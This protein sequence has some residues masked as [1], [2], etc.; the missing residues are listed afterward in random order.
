MRTPLIFTHYGLSDY[1]PY[2]L[3]QARK[4][5]PSK[6]CVLIGD[7]YNKNIA[8]DCG[9]KHIFIDEI[10]S[11]KRDEFNARFKWIQGPHHNPIRGGKDWLRYVSERFFV[12]EAFLTNENIDSLWHFDSDTMIIH[13]LSDY[14]AILRKDNIKCTT[15]C[16]D[17]CPSGYIY[18]SV[19]KDFCSSMIDD[20]NDTNFINEQQEE[21][22]NINLGYAY[23][24][25]RAFKRFRKKTGLA[26]AKLSS[27]FSYKSIWFDE[28]ICQEHGFK[29]IYSA[30]LGRSIKNFYF[31]D[32]EIYATTE[33]GKEFCFAIINCSWVTTDVFAWIERV[34]QNKKPSFRLI[35]S[36]GLKTSQKVK[37][38]FSKILK[39]LRLTFRRLLD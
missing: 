31:Y 1:L 24:E 30:K 34:S 8:L 32:E 35:D 16:N 37:L 21:F 6:E 19:I 23:T 12:I 4:S 7:K 39:K 25:M 5:N 9:W 38:L 20:F 13:E 2:T 18:S 22:D 26:T 36:L 27:Y 28:C 10:K 11:N 3:R 15:L 33:Q 14:E 29:T 17:M